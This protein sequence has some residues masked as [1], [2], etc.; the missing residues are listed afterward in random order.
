[1]DNVGTKDD[2]F[3]LATADHEL[4]CKLYIDDHDI[5]VK[6]CEAGPK[7]TDFSNI[8]FDAVHR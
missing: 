3:T 5:N 6:A 4:C 1:M 8:Q 2:E 7:V